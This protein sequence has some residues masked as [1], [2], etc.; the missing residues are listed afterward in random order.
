[1]AAISDIGVSGIVVVRVKLRIVFPIES[2]VKLR[3]RMI[4]TND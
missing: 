2:R 1:M 3:R 4:F